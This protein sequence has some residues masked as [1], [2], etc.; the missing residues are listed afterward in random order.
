MSVVTG[1]ALNVITVKEAEIEQARNNMANDIISEIL[2]YARCH[3]QACD[4]RS[5][6][7]LEKLAA[8]LQKAIKQ[9]KSGCKHLDD[10]KWDKWWCGDCGDY[11]VKNG[12]RGPRGRSGNDEK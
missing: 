1:E 4:E 9:E 12:C 5:A 10:P 7:V 2:I 6:A 11:C 3:K 8:I